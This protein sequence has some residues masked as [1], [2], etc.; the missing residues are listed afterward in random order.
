MNTAAQSSATSI[1][2]SKTSASASSTTTLNSDPTVPNVSS[3][4]PMVAG[5]LAGVIVIVAAV[6]VI[7]LVR[8]RR[9]VII[10]RA[11]QNFPSHSA[12]NAPAPFPE[13]PRGYVSPTTNPK[14]PFNV[15]PL[16]RTPSSP[17]DSATP[18]IKGPSSRYSLSSED[19]ELNPRCSAPRH[20]HN[21][22]PHNNGRTTRRGSSSISQSLALS[23]VA[24][25]TTR[26]DDASHLRQGISV[27]DLDRRNLPSSSDQLHPLDIDTV[28]RNDPFSTSNAPSSSTQLR[29]EKGRP[30]PLPK[31]LP[32]PH[33]GDLPPAY[34]SSVTMAMLELKAA[35]TSDELFAR[36]S[37]GYK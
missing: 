7:F 10:R 11:Q 16:S 37:L 3:S 27:G 24:D 12:R 1:S 36:G 8:H 15:T 32:L 31:R 35:S 20:S 30:K 13:G 2:Q 14:D 21:R 28:P 19:V 26:T 5:T 25:M 22:Q 6:A 9:N 33:D 29:P 34:D 18:S 4:V 17:I 23:A